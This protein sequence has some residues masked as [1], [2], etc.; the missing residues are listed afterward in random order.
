MDIPMVP[1]SR[2]VRWHRLIHDVLGCQMGAG[3]DL[4]DLAQFKWQLDQAGIHTHV[5]SEWLEF[6]TQ[7][8][9]GDA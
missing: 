1:Q 7:P 5:V 4:A 9:K 8:K 2:R 6:P 3:V